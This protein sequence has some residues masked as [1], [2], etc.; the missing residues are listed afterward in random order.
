MTVW[1]IARVKDEADVIAATV[2]HMLGEVDCVLVEDN[3]SSDG[4][5]E[6]LERLSGTLIVQGDDEV[7]Y[8]QAAHM[9]RLAVQ[10]A[11]HGAEFV[12]PFDA[13]EIWYSPFGRVGDVLLDHPEALIATAEMHDHVAT[14]ADPE[15]DPVT[16]MGWR[17]RSPGELPKVACRPNP[18]VRIHQGNHG[19]DY[20]DTLHGLLQVRH[21]PYR[22]EAQFERKVRNGAAAYAATDLPEHEGE[23]WRG[24]GRILDEGGPEALAEVF[25]KWFWVAEPQTQPE[26]IYDP[27]P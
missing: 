8:Y 21:F 10:A 20:G 12:I 11:E 27:A 6:I 5:R 19:A 23:H 26:L 24:Y 13:D 18:P 15:G 17:R 3:D 14:G 7:A 22:S 25:R 9:S 4:T 2:Q 1:G 16:R